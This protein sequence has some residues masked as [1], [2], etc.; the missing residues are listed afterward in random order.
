MPGAPFD[1]LAV[2]IGAERAR[3]EEQLAALA[4]IEAAVARYGHGI[5]ESGYEC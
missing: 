4:A 3:L 5:R 2:T 1:A